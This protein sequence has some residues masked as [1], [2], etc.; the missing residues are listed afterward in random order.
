MKHVAGDLERTTLQE[1]GAVQV[2]WTTLASLVNAV[3]D[4]GMDPHEVTVTGYVEVLE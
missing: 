2:H 4:L 3:Q 1:T